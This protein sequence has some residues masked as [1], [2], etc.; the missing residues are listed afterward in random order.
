MATGF[1]GGPMGGTTTITAGGAPFGA[2]QAVQPV[3][4]AAAAMAPAPVALALAPAPAPAAMARAPAPAPAAII[5]GARAPAP[6]PS[7]RGPKSRKEILLEEIDF[8]L[9]K[10]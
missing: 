6:S 8:I 9:T 5:Y 2:G 10:I 4:A 1:G 7:S 3:T